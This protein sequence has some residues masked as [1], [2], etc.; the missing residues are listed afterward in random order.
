MSDRDYTDLAGDV[1]DCHNIA[2]LDSLK[3]SEAR[4]GMAMD[5]GGAK[6]RYYCLLNPQATNH[7]NRGKN[8]AAFHNELV[9]R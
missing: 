5:N 3:F 7:F 8:L 1:S 2:I 4:G 6:G 9:L